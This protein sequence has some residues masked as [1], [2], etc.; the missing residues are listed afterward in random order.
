MEGLKSTCSRGTI[1]TYDIKTILD[2]IQELWKGW[3]AEYDRTEREKEKTPQAQR[4]RR[5]TLI[6]EARQDSIDDMF[7]K[8]TGTWKSSEEE[9]E[10]DRFL[11]EPASSDSDALAWWTQPAQQKRWPRLSRFSISIFSFPAMSDEPERI[12]SGG[13]RLIRWDRAQLRPDLIEAS[14]CLFHTFNLEAQEAQ[15]AL[16]RN[17]P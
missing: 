2:R 3:V 9:D 13:R 17:N 1:E 6:E 10:F 5:E 4:R 15:E 16:D 14:E 12:F 8:M 11:R 7:K